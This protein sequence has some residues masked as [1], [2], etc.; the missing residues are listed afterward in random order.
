MSLFPNLSN[1]SPSDTRCCRD[2]VA[3][4]QEELKDL[5]TWKL[6]NSYHDCLAA[7]LTHQD[8]EMCGNATFFVP[9][10]L[11]GSGLPAECAGTSMR[12][13]AGRVG[14]QSRSAGELGARAQGQG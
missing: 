10:P 1:W 14:I 11:P 9:G 5:N 3:K 7:F 2:L 12:A 8:L 4:M 13:Q 6:A